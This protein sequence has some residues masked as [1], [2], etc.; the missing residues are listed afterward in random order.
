MVTFIQRLK[1]FLVAMTLVLCISFT[2]TI[3]LSGCSRRLSPK[4]AEQLI[5]EQ[6]SAPVPMRTRLYLDVDYEA[7]FTL[8]Q[9]SQL[10]EAGVITFQY[11][12]HGK[13]RKSYT[14]D[15]TELGQQYVLETSVDSRGDRWV[16][17]KT[18][19]KKFIKVIEVEF[20]QQ[21][22]WGKG[23]V[24]NAFY[25][26][27]YD[28]VTPFVAIATGRDCENPDEQQQH[29]IRFVLD[30]DGWQ[31]NPPLNQY[32]GLE[33]LTQRADIGEESNSHKAYK[34]G[35]STPEERG[36][37]D[38]SDPK[39]VAAK[40]SKIKELRAAIE[41]VDLER[42]KSIQGIETIINEVN[43]SGN[44]PLMQEFF[45]NSSKEVLEHLNN[46]E[47]HRQ[48]V[49]YLISKG[50]D[51]NKVNRF[52]ETPLTAAVQRNFIGFFDLL[53][54]NGA[55]ID[56]PESNRR[57]PLKIA[58][59]NNSFDAVKY[60]LERGADP[61]R[62]D[63]RGI[64]PLTEA[65]EHNRAEIVEILLKNGARISATDENPRTKRQH[66][67][68]LLMMVA[69]RGH[70]DVVKLLVEAGAP[71]NTQDRLSGR[72]AFSSAVASGKFDVAEY[73]KQQDKK[74]AKQQ[75]S[76]HG[77]EMLI[78]A[79]EMGRIEVVKYLLE[80]GVEVKEGGFWLSDTT[81][82]LLGKKSEPKQEVA[83]IDAAR[84]GH[85][86][87]VKLLV[88]AGAP[89]NEQDEWGHTALM[90]AARF[91]RSDTAKYLIKTGADVNLKETDFGRNAL[92]EAVENNCVE[93]VKHLLTVEGID[94]DA[95]EDFRKKRTALQIA[96]DRKNEETA[97]LLRDYKAA[98]T[99]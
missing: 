83:L 7:R 14:V 36:D 89:V 82:K 97:K 44:T 10:Q 92:M 99:Q 95:K 22:H 61:N 17:V 96:E 71:V 91:C 43:A 26:W 9:Y 25:E 68:A 74:S 48:I 63:K 42:I 16:D 2:S 93:V 81:N 8:Q 19:E 27:K 76:E 86:D 15:I 28:N 21:K 41:S 87:I 23:A 40:N 12:D 85:I 78:D 13:G 47:I 53:L 77:Q 31:I 51:V 39:L 67:G 18:C 75:L 60:L 84:K 56:K 1:T 69:A 5:T 79:S 37:E 90:V 65:A 46:F 72:T 52:G 70:I 24:A 6:W 35:V 57:T 62:Y 54:D 58:V 11:T 34:E 38:L 45:L 98:K 20:F 3:F 32:S 80:N 59:E 33:R 55:E 50:A 88:K 4:K 29:W 94:I 49:A 30:D 73:L 64:F 66:P